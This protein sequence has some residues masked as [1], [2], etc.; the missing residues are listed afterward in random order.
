[1]KK[2]TKI[3]ALLVAITFTTLTTFGQQTTT[4]ETGGFTWNPNVNT[5]T[6]KTDGYKVYITNPGVIVSQVVSSSLASTNLVGINNVVIYNR[7]WTLG[8]LANGSYIFWLNAYFG[9]TNSMFV[10]LPFILT[11][12]PVVTVPVPTNLRI[13]NQ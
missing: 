2:L 7:N 1:M 11:S 3:L 10:S 12:V 9:T 6:N 8:T 13:V 4:K 5:A